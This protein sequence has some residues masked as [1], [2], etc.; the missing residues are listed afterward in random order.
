MVASYDAEYIWSNNA[1]DITAAA[2]A[3][4]YGRVSYKRPKHTPI[5]FHLQLIS[6]FGVR[7]GPASRVQSMT[8]WG[9]GRKARAGVL[10]VLTAGL[11]SRCAATA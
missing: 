9:E 3:I 8:Q 10:V 7:T 5:P 4:L 1:L 2:I 6:L 11:G